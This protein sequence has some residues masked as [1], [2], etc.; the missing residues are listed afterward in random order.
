MNPILIGARSLEVPSDSNSR[1]YK[2]DLFRKK[3]VNFAS[4]FP[5]RLLI[6][7][8]LERSKADNK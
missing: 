7:L 8:A 1:G 5:K 6:A 2:N 3:G 4:D